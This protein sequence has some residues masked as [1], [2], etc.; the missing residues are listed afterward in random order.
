[1]SAQKVI[2]PLAVIAV[3]GVVTYMAIS[4][5]PEPERAVPEPLSPPVEFIE[6]SPE[7]VQLTVRSQGTVQPRTET[8][9]I[10]EV[11]GRIVQVSPDFEPGGFFKKGE[12][13]L[14]IDDADLKA[15]L[16]ME[17]SALAQAEF[18]L[19]QE[20]AL[21]EQARIDWEDLGEGDPTALALRE[22]Q[23]KQAK[24]AMESAQARVEKARRDLERST[25]KAP[26]ACLIEEQLVDL[27]GYVTGSPGTPLA[28]IY[29]TDRAEVRLPLS[30]EQLALIE[31]PLA[32]RGEAAE[33]GPE[34]MLSARHGTQDYT[35]RGLITRMEAS[36][37]ER[38]RLLYVVAVVDDPYGRDPE[39]PE[40]PPLR[41]GLFV[42]AEIQGRSVPEA[43]VVPRYA[44]REGN[45][46]LV[47]GPDDTLQRKAVTVIHATDEQAILREGL[48]PGDRV[49]I[50][51]ME[52]AVEGM[53]VTPVSSHQPS[54]NS[55]QAEFQPK[56]EVAKGK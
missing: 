27:G 35:W 43:F 33:L 42:E 53:A 20:E 50:S 9:L 39:H 44:L 13:L 45:T 21:A 47:A 12:M 1:M 36:V 14:Q 41:A 3:A 54:A 8:T 5:K 34:V 17:E 19:L 11:G 2:L 52:Y 7:T 38:S 22:P 18:T 55:Q 10:S 23:I 24:A 37:D 48:S 40:R 26:Y 29:A 30:T 49:I 4:L 15:A 25:V 32:Y 46:I 51:P 16:A 56:G 31:L 6:A 28:R